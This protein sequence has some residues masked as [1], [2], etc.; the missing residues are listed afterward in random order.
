MSSLILQ[1]GIGNRSEEIHFW[2]CGRGDCPAAD[3]ATDFE[4]PEDWVTDVLLATYV[5]C[6]FVGIAVTYFFVMP[7]PKSDWIVVTSTKQS[8]TSFF[9]VLRSTAI[10]LLVPLFIFQG[11]QQAVLFSEFTRVSDY[12]YY[13]SLDPVQ[14]VSFTYSS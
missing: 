5:T 14:C 2:Q 4:E 8:V 6:D 1:N 7:L 13:T 11:M 12:F 10:A 3:N 9:V